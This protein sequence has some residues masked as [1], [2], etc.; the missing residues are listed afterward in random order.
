MGADLGWVKGVCEQVTVRK[1]K[2]FSYAGP[3]TDGC[4]IA[5]GPI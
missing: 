4:S 5:H 2:V 1:V 3:P